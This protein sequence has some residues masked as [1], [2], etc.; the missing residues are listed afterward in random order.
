MHG[1]KH[2]LPALE[3][4][5]RAERGFAEPPRAA[6][7]GLEDRLDVGGR[8]A[9]DAQ[10]FARRRLVVERFGE[11]AVAGLQFLRE[12]VLLDRDGRLDGESLKQRDLLWRERANLQAAERDDTE[13]SVSG[14]ERRHEHR[15]DPRPRDLGI[16]RPGDSLEVADLDD[17]PLESRATVD[18][19]STQRKRFSQCSVRAQRSVLS[20]QTQGL[21]LDE[22][23]LGV[24]SLAKARRRLGDGIKDRVGA[25]WPARGG[26]RKSTPALWADGSTGSSTLSAPTTNH[27]APGA[28]AM[29]PCRP[30]TRVCRP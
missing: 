4:V 22:D 15:S 12:P 7:D 21:A 10:D 25:R 26:H 17:T 11:L 19:A 1:R 6:D 13:D 30:R 23:N 28:N 18:R 2:Q 3:K 24:A 27:V 5:Q 14:E 20:D 29:G 16:L 9:D 8:G